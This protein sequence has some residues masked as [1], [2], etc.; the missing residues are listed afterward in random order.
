MSINLI[1]GMLLHVVIS[2]T[3]GQQCLKDECNE[4]NPSPDELVLLNVLDVIEKHVDNHPVWTTMYTPGDTSKETIEPLPDI[5]YYR[6]HMIGSIPFFL[7][8]KDLCTIVF[9]YPDE[10][11]DTVLKGFINIHSMED[12]TH[13]LRYFE[14][15]VKIGLNELNSPPD[16][17]YLEAY[18]DS[19]TYFSRKAIYKIVQLDGKLN[20]E[21]N[22]IGRFVILHAFEYMANLYFETITQT[23]V[24]FMSS[25][26]VDVNNKTI[27]NLGWMSHDHI[28]TDQHHYDFDHLGENIT[29]TYPWLNEDMNKFNFDQDVYCSKIEN[30][31]V[32][33]EYKDA[34][35]KVVDVMAE[36]FDQVS[37]FIRYGWKYSVYSDILRYPVD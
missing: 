21:I 2:P 22:D 12:G 18:N 19:Q 15:F 10:N 17:I 25:G 37:E 13:Y 35:I 8:F 23:Y 1:F 33:N 28:E 31:Q 30:D 11:V 26:I 36:C 27:N 20:G 4:C 16:K 32:F 6:R 9:P 5:I 29:Q 3:Y 14:D 24:R 7:Y 34:G